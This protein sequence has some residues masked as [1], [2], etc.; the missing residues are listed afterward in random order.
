M[1]HDRI[2]LI[3]GVSLVLASCAARGAG[4]QV[5]EETSSITP[6]DAQCDA[7]TD[8]A[9]AWMATKQA[10][11]GHWASG[12]GRNTGVC[13]LAIM[14]F[15]AKGHLPGEGPYGEVIKRGI[16][17]VVSCQQGNGLLV[18]NT[19]HGP[20]YSHAVATLMLAEVVG[21]VGGE[22][23]RRVRDALAKAVKVL[24]DA[25]KLRRGRHR[26]GWRYQHTGNDADISVTGWCVMSLKAAKNCG[27]RVP[28]Q[29]IDEAIDYIKRS[30]VRG[31]GFSYQAQSGGPNVARTGT[32]ILCLE[33]AGY[34]Q[35]LA[36]GKRHHDEAL[37][38]G[39]W[40]LKNP[41]RHF[42]G[43]HFYYGIYYSS[44]AMFQLGGRF[45][46]QWF[47][48]LERLVL[49]NQKADGSWPSEHGSG[50]AAGPVYSTAMSVLALSIKYRYLPIYQR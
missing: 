21:M 1:N 31:G 45:W 11:D 25:Q 46:K 32:G 37:E 27:A 3:I 4:A 39:A 20:M 49:A 18:K 44:Q 36:S 42:N 15:L 38:G 35:L 2:L 5:V 48:P 33:I 19:S 8:K 9:L 6:L 14:A 10:A 40:L 34:H 26:G 24:L 22:R 41:Y 13:S 29:A 23:Q 47:V 28:V 30:K 50:Q 43:S 7:A 17:F 12:Y 16:D